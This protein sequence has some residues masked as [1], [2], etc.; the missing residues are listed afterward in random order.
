MEGLKEGFW[1]LRALHAAGRAFFLGGLG[2]LRFQGS[3][4]TPCRLQC[5]WSF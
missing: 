1:E 2:V 5:L 4:Y 3:C